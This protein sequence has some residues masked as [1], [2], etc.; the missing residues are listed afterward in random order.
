MCQGSALD[1][2]SESTKHPFMRTMT[3]VV[4]LSKASSVD[5][6]RGV[7]DKSWSLLLLLLTA[8][9]RILSRRKH[10]SAIKPLYGIHN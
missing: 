9:L 1:N 7:V 3:K 8:T 5:C 4:W 2:N 6:I 10:E